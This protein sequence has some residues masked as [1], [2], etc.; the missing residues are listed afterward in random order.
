VTDDARRPGGVR[1]DVG[2]DDE[3]RRALL[4]AARRD[5]GL[6]AGCGRALADGEPVW[7]ARLALRG[8]Y[9]WISHRWGPAGRECAPPETLRATDGREPARCV[10][11]GRGV[12][13]ESAPPPRRAPTCSKRCAG[14]YRMA[15]AREARGS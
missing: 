15:R 6:C 2:D 7:W 3:R 8:A 12:Y 11:C 5:G 13:Y 14:R 1:I 9:G 4:H 10:G